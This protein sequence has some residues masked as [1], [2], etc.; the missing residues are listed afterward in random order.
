MVLDLERRVKLWSPAAA[1]IFGWQ[2]AEVLGQPLPIVP[3][4]ERASS[5]ELLERARS[6]ESVLEYERA[7][8]PKT[9]PFG[10]SAYGRRPS[11]PPTA[12]L[13]AT[14]SCAATSPSANGS[15]NNS[16]TRSAWKASAFWPAGSRTIS[17]TS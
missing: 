8:A 5:E 17:I 11:A 6:G 4:E 3:E 15:T 10:T 12:R 16:G 9:G 7:A 13:A 2:A 14:S 1:R